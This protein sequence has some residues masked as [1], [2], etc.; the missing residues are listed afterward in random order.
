M[1]AL[2]FFNKL[3]DDVQRRH[4]MKKER[5]EFIQDVQVQ[6][7][8]ALYMWHNHTFLKNLAYEISNR[9]L[10]DVGYEGGLRLAYRFELWD[11]EGL[12]DTYQ[13]L[14][15]VWDE[16]VKMLSLDVKPEERMDVV[17]FGMPLKEKEE[18]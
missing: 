15:S 2:T 1:N 8:R 14:K 11:D 7:G 18:A 5:V 10:Y 12:I 9:E 13:M 4:N 3:K 16:N 17:V 6:K